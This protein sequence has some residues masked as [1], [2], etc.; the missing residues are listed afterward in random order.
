MKA[1]LLRSSSVAAQSPV[2][3]T[4]DGVVQCRQNSLTRV[5]SGE[6][7]ADGSPRIALHL[8]VNRWTGGIRRVLSD[9]E[10]IKPVGRSSGARSMSRVREEMHVDSGEKRTCLPLDRN[11]DEFWTRS[12]V[13]VDEVGSSGGGS[14][15]GNDSGGDHVSGGGFGRSRKKVGEYYQQMLKSNPGD[16]LLLRNYGKYLHEVPPR[17]V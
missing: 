5:F 11:L 13:L 7:A 14:G 12:G 3:P 1:L 9:T 6:R 10:V 17:V 15:K 2:I 16:P 8:K 4:S